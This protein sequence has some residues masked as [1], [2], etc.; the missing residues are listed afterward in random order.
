MVVDANAVVNPRAMMVKSF[1]TT[2]A[3]CTMLRSW[4]SED[5]T[6]RTHFTRMN[7]CKNLH[8]TEVFFNIARIM[9]AC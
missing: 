3:N 2:I 4:C 5:F 7:F 6:V 8:K 1:N 9:H